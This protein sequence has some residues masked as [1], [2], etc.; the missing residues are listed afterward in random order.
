MRI[1]KMV[2]SL[3]YFCAA[4]IFSAQAIA[5]TGMTY[6]GRIVQPNGRPLEVANVFFHIQ[7][8]SPG[9]EN[10]L[11]F[12]EAQTVNMTGSNGVFVVTIGD[13]IRVGA[14]VDGGASF[15][16]IFANRGTLTSPTCAFGGVY[17]PNVADGRKL[18]VEFSDG[19]AWQGLPAQNIN[20]VPLAIEAMQVSGYG[21][22]QLL[23]VA[24]GVTATEF[25]SSNW[26][27]L[28]NY[29]T[30]AGAASGDV[31]KWNGTAWVPGVAAP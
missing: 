28:W 18:V 29:L 15:E 30:G 1:I 22:D 6:H 23:R 26:T 9:A 25:S 27:A 19:G 16:K 5:A 31:L 4:L 7:I 11:L 3:A 21:K 17:N 14:G 10:C 13:G 8:R 20:Y 2:T 12:D 24:D